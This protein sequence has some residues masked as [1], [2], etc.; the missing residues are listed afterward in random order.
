MTVSPE[1]ERLPEIEQRMRDIAFNDGIEAAASAI[2]HDG[3][4]DEDVKLIVGILYSCKRNIPAAA[5][6]TDGVKHD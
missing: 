6:Q 1:Q 5:T 2:E 4:L 3:R